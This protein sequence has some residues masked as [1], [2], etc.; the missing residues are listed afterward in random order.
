MKPK[1]LA[2][3]QYLVGT[4]Y[5]LPRIIPWLSYLLCSSWD[6]CL[7]KSF[8]SSFCLGRTWLSRQNQGNCFCSH[9][10]IH[11]C[12]VMTDSRD[13]KWPLQVSLSHPEGT[14]SPFHISPRGP[15]A[16]PEKPR[17]WCEATATVVPSALCAGGTT[18]APPLWKFSYEWEWPVCAEESTVEEKG[19]WEI[20]QGPDGIQ[21]SFSKN[22]LPLLTSESRKWD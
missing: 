3:A 10:Q 20:G 5:L 8:I 13:C 12:S 22:F 4:Q 7:L 15:K 19:L 17:E 9:F 2:I 16:W 21:T 11:L 1:Y 18:N 6:H 14:L